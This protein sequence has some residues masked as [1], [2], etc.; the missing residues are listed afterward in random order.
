MKP[1]KTP[2]GPG[3]AS[4]SR[5]LG[6]VGLPGRGLRG[7][8]KPQPCVVEAEVSAPFHRHGDRGQQAGAT[9]AQGREPRQRQTAWKKEWPRGP[10]AGDS[11]AQHVLPSWPLE[12]FRLLEASI[13][14]MVPALAGSQQP[15]QRPPFCRNQGCESSSLAGVTKLVSGSTGLKPAG[16]QIHALSIVTCCPSPSCEDTQTQRRPPCLVSKGLSQSR[17]G[18]RVPA[19][20][21]MP[22][23]HD[24][25]RG[26]AAEPLHRPLPPLTCRPGLGGAGRP[27]TAAHPRAGSSPGS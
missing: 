17:A 5:A 13:L 19:H 25:H 20:A 4:R 18:T 9:Q 3:R 10:R 26:V 12:C 8:A 24:V 7:H 22:C 1:E 16:P 23:S 11:L 21:A 2:A 14:W 27:A 15:P 6:E